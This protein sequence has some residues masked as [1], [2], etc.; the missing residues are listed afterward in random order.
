MRRLTHRRTV[1]P[2]GQQSASD[3]RVEAGHGR[4]SEGIGASRPGCG[5]NRRSRRRGEPGSGPAIT[6]STLHSRHLPLLRRRPRH[7]HRPRP[8]PRPRRKR[9]ISTELL[10]CPSYLTPPLPPRRGGG[11]GVGF[12]SHAR[13]LPDSRRGLAFVH[14]SL[15]EGADHNLSG[16]RA[17][18]DADNQRFE[19]AL[20][21]AGLLK[22]DDRSCVQK[23]DVA[24]SPAHCPLPTPDCPHVNASR[25]RYKSWY[26]ATLPPDRANRERGH[27]Y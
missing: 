13:R 4:R 2:H 5:C 10:D 1:S 3:P 21:R 18:P 6:D 14:R 12:L 22:S 15:R 19:V 24:P 7:R 26:D 11:W 23:T 16:R 8:A 9:T 20:G 17:V 27:D 25:V